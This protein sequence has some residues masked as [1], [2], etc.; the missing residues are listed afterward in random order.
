MQTLL[1]PSDRKSGI[2]NRIVPLQMLSIM[3]LTYIFKVTNFEMRI[4]GKLWELAKNAHV[5]LSYMF[6]LSNGTITNGLCK[7][8]TYF[9][10]KIFQIQITWKWWELAK[11][12]SFGFYRFWYLPLN[13]AIPKAVD[14]DAGILFQRQIYLSSWRQCVLSK[15]V[16]YDFY[17][18]WSL[19]SK[20]NHC[21]NHSVTL[22]N[23]FKVK[24]ANNN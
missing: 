3:T 19:L 13:G 4:S 24:I 14:C 10:R 16:K 2:C 8:L 11:N 21:K 7:H 22:T 6:I 18:C 9:S 15:N 1:L 23:I 12:V 5:W 17:T 20:W